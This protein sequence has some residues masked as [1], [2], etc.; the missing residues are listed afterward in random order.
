MN[1]DRCAGILKQF[2]G[3]VKESWGRLV[4][5]PRVVTAGIRD[6]FAGSIQERYGVS[7]EKAARQLKEFL[8]RNRN[9]YRLSR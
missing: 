5:N 2:R 6:Q 7:K 8:D 9:W 1:Q 4:N 3:K